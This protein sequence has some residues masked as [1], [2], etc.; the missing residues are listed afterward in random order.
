MNEYKF[1]TINGVE[2]KE[3]GEGPAPPRFFRV[4]FPGFSGFP[5]V[6]PASAVYGKIPEHP[7]SG[8]EC[9]LAMIDRLNPGISP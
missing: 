4:F 7:S 8:T 1:L 6:F 5:V 9:R 2:M 3:T